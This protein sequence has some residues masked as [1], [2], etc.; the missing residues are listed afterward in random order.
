MM[1]GMRNA[2]ADLRSVSPRETGTSRP[3]ARVFEDQQGRPAALLFDHGR[4]GG[5]GEFAQ[6]PAHVVIAFAAAAVARFIP[7]RSV[8]RVRQRPRRRALG[9]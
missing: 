7:G 8:R 2:P 5:A 1:S 9:G 4:V 6:Q 3:L